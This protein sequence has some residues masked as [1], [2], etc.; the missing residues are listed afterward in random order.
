MLYQFSLYSTSSLTVALSANSLFI[1][2]LKFLIKLF[3]PLSCYYHSYSRPAYIVPLSY[4]SL[5]SSQISN[6]SPNNTSYLASNRAAIEKTINDYIE[7]CE[8][9]N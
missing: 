8:G 3:P 7:G 1:V 5:C 2:A 6:D 4:Y 9:Y